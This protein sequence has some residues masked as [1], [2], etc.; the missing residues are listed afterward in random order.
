M[1]VRGI[2]IGRMQHK[3]EPMPYIDKPGLSDMQNN[4]LN[5]LTNLFRSVSEYGLEKMWRC[6]IA[7]QFTR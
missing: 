6:I 7:D 2:T 1:A 4:I 5:E 3:I